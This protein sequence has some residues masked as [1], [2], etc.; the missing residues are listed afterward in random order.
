M[1]RNVEE[2]TADPATIQGDA[3]R[4]ESEPAKG[5]QIDSGSPDVRPA[6]P[7][8]SEGE[9]TS[10]AADREESAGH[11]PQ[12]TLDDPPRGMPCGIAGSGP[13]AP[14]ED[15]PD[16]PDLDP[17]VQSRLKNCSAS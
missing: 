9:D 8:L 10:D 14:A 11:P 15:T 7:L 2:P 6:E 4:A 1:K 5:N 16:E 12:H 13:H 17:E 3:H